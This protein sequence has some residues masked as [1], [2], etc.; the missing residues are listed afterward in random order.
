[1][2]LKVIINIILF[3]FIVLCSHYVFANESS[4]SK[5]RILVFHSMETNRPLH[6]YFNSLLRQEIYKRSVCPYVLNFENLDLIRFHS[7]S[8]KNN[9]K[10]MLYQKYSA[11][12]PD[13]IIIF[14]SQATEFVSEYNLFPEIP[15][16]YITT[17]YNFKNK[18]QFPNNSVV[19]FMGYDFKGNVEHCLEL[20]PDTNQFFVIRGNGLIDKSFE[21]TFREN[22]KELKR[23]VKFEYIGGLKIEKL[24]KR[25]ENLPD[26][27]LV[28]YLP[29]TMDDRGRPCY[30][31][32]IAIKIGERTNKPVFSF[33]DQ[34]VINSG[35]LGGRITSVKSIADW[36]SKVVWQVFKGKS[37]TS[38]DS[39]DFGHKYMYDWQ[40]L[41]KWGIDEKK[42]PPN[43]IVQNRK[44][45]FFELYKWRIIIG[46]LILLFES[47]LIFIL[48]RV[49]TK[50]KQ[51]SIALN[52]M[53]LR[54]KE[55]MASHALLQEQVKQLDR[56]E[57]IGTFTSAVAHEIN[58]P[59][60]AIRCNAQAAIR[61]LNAK[62]L[63]INQVKEAL[64]DI[65]SDNKRAADVI[66]WLRMIIKKDEPMCEELAVM[67]VIQE[68]VDL[69]QSEISI[70]NVSISK[71]YMEGIPS[72]YC[73]K[74]QIQHVMINL[75]VN[76][77]DAV[78]EK[79]E[80]N[81]EVQVSIRI[82]K[83]D[84][85]LVS[86][87]DSGS[88]IKII[89]LETVFDTFYTTKKKGMGIGLSICKSIVENHDGRIWASNNPQGGA[90]FSFTLPINR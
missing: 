23:Q 46:I 10:T 44:Y 38:I 5:K 80:G 39:G 29:Y 19:G 65:V 72:V 20:F 75:L 30:A 66:L 4:M 21:H 34:L 77:L 61:F 41:K 79:P 9:L 12:H 88:G 71:D 43:S 50:L 85:I 60:A 15:R 31:I 87:S 36:V 81:R 62:Q 86:I 76:A 52:K 59:L 40:K 63:D 8:Y 18:V 57:T 6:I 70:N 1:M 17:E 25:V 53:N 74:I 90:V 27:S 33:V 83:N 56:V 28:Y 45:N 3:V 22:T 16:I 48:L 26:Y 14:L 78:K 82:E 32:D 69:L 2:N 7:K 64:L 58:Q 49:N 42:L 47:F 35:I 51:S 54:L 24:L 68:I 73:D 11:L 37:I 84:N 89:N 55:T 67:D 13:I